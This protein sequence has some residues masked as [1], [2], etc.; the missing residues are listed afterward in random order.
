M[1]NEELLAIADTTGFSL[2]DVQ[3]FCDALKPS[4]KKKEDIIAILTTVKKL[5]WSIKLAIIVLDMHGSYSNLR[6]IEKHI[7]DIQ[8]P[9]EET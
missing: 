9:P 8:I 1:K 5:N 4:S 3:S 7:N 2:E 6:E